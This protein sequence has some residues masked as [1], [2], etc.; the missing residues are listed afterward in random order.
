M[1]ILEQKRPLT[2][3]KFGRSFA[4]FNQLS[5]ARRLGGLDGGTVSGLAFLG[6]YS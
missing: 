6:C 1:I 4:R 3:V 5:A 2:G